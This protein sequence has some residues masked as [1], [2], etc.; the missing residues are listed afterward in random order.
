M[1]MIC[2][3]AS[4]VCCAPGARTGP[5]WKIPPVDG[6]GLEISRKAPFLLT[7]IH[8]EVFSVLAAAP[9]TEVGIV[10]AVAD[11]EPGPAPRS[12]REV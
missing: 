12:S 5:E 9:G 6:T 2:A 3:S 8:G 4:V 1:S 10:F 11:G 7:F